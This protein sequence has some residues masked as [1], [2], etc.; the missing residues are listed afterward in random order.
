MKKNEYETIYN[1]DKKEFLIEKEE[2]KK[3][4]FLDSKIIDDNNE[5][6][7]LIDNNN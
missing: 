3:L 5:N 4:E 1:D 7:K 6:E 2:D